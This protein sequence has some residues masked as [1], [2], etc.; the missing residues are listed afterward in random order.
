MSAKRAEIAAKRARF[1]GPGGKLKEKEPGDEKEELKEPAAA[2]EA[3]NQNERL[4]EI[5]DDYLTCSICKQPMSHSVVLPCGDMFC[6]YCINEWFYRWP[7]KCPL[8]RKV[9][10]RSTTTPVLH[11]DRLIRAAVCVDSASTAKHAER[12]KSADAEY[13]ELQ[14][15]I[16]KD[17]AEKDARDSK[18]AEEALKVSSSSEEEDDED[19]SDRSS[20]SDAEE[21]EEEEE[22]PDTR[23]SS[24]N[25]KPAPAAAS[26]RATRGQKRK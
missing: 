16:K 6:R 7:K 26:S 8:C 18:D 23:R 4:T 10:T 3:G 2:I 15:Q 17:R 9:H 25:A 21:E 14:E 20:E 19:F 1:F 5:T 24:R 13:A 12:L 11:V 22:Q